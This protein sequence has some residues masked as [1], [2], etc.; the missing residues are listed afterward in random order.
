MAECRENRGENE[1]HVHTA[2]S[3]LIS[4]CAVDSTKTEEDTVV[5][6]LTSDVRHSVTLLSH[7]ELSE[8]FREPVKVSAMR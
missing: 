7:E 4:T 6:Q 8:A 2:H 1:H 3:Y 5:V